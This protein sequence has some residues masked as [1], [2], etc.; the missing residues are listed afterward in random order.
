MAISDDQKLSLYNGACR[1]CGEARLATLTDDREA[2]YL[3]D[4]VWTLGRGAVQGMLEAG[5]WYFAMR[6]SKLTYDT[7]AT[8]VFGYRY[9]FEKP[10]DW[11]KTA[12]MCQDERFQTPLTQ[13]VDES[14][15]FYADLQTLYLSYVS[16]DD[17]FGLNFGIWPQSFIDA[18]SGWLA[19]RI[20]AKLTAGSDATVK[21][22][23]GDANSLMKRAKSNAAMNDSAAFFPTG[24]WVRSRWGNRGFGDRGNTGQLIG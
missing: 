5:Y 4:D 18:A 24:A 22:V 10:A 7:L 23:I 21:R 15:Y 1:M 2:R 9:A 13:I 20:V 14:G 3:L 11:V 17:L 8:P 6:S 16:N 19:E 12:K